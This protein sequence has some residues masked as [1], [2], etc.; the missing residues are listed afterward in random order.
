MARKSG[1][2]KPAKNEDEQLLD[3]ISS[4]PEVVYQFSAEK[5]GA[6]ELNF[7]SAQSRK[8]FGLEPETKDFLRLFT[9]HIAPECREGFLSSIQSAFDTTSEW[10]YE[11]RFIKDSGEVVWFHGHSSPV[12][13][14]NHTVFNGVLADITARKNEESRRESVIRECSESKERFQG[15]YEASFG[16][17]GVHDR[18]LIIEA[19]KAL[20]DITGYVY[21]ELIGMDGLLLIAPES[22]Q[23][24]MQHIESG[25][26]HPYE[27]VGLKKDGSRYP[28]AIQGKAIPCKGKQVRVT[29]FRDIAAQKEVEQS[30]KISEERY[31]HLF[32]NSGIAMVT[33][34]DRGLISACNREC[35]NLT[36]YSVKEIAGKMSWQD[37]MASDADL[38]RLAEYRRL[39]DIDESLAPKNYEFT[40]KTKEG[41]HQY[42]ETTV[43]LSPDKTEHLVVFNDITERKRAEE[44]IRESERRLLSTIEGSPIPT[45]VI[46]R[47]HRV[48]FWNRALAQISGIPHDEIVGTGDHWRAFYDHPR[49]CMADLLLDGKIEE[50]GKLY[51]GNYSP[52]VLVEGAYEAIDYFPR[53][54]TNGKWLRFTAAAIRDSSGSI[55]G[56]IETLEDITEGK[57]SERQLRES[58]ERYRLVFEHSPIGI[59]HI[60][61]KG[62]TLDANEKWGEIMGAARESF[63]GFNTL[64]NI[65]DARMLQSIR[66]VLEGKP[67]YFEAEY[68]SVVSGKKSIIQFIS[69]PIFS[70]NGAV[71]GAIGICQDITQRHLTE[72]ALRDSLREK[73]VL[74]KEIH[75]RVKNNL[76]IVVSLLGLQVHRETSEEAKYSLNITRS[77]IFAISLIHELLYQMGN[78]SRIDFGA[79]IRKLVTQLHGVLIDESMN[80]DEM[81]NV[82]S[83]SLDIE[84]A[85]PCGIL[86]SE[87]LTN[88]YKHAFHGRGRGSISIEMTAEP[89]GYR[90]SIGDDGGGLPEGVDFRTTT[91]L[92]MEL[93][94]MLAETQLR[95][96][97]RHWNDNGLKYAITIPA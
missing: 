52:S 56:A 29:E 81:I 82:E 62:R 36:G 49:P 54:H 67:D 30:L 55:T 64:A 76:N 2:R 26:E 37:F 88:A 15:L 93:I 91:S 90:L 92:G 1:S 84:K 13:Y 94:R 96:T 22:R 5:G 65:Q 63:I 71:S 32:E 39:R 41:A 4:I 79:Y 16:G 14:K 28:L 69:Q 33:I 35:A 77:R 89:G 51:E 83:I 18:G 50:I 24:V 97:L 38:A 58:E 53:M 6:M 70:P 60:D 73:K 9:A 46:D 17:I 85:V 21:D 11:G 20:S 66:Q 3:M 57:E 31:R 10:N 59:N 23:M 78:L 47:N 80:I 75:H 12:S 95:G 45:F 43:V 19:N 48:V 72:R 74:L 27:A 8:I 34:D 87:I 42:M 25:D 61:A 68:T 86:V 40:L 44:A 7:V